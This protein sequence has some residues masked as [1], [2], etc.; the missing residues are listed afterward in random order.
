MG[1]NYFCVRVIKYEYM[2]EDILDSVIESYEEVEY[3][4]K[5]IFKCYLKCLGYFMSK[6]ER[7]FLLSLKWNIVREIL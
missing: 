6:L 5:L 1:L 2:G 3:L 4:V 7:D